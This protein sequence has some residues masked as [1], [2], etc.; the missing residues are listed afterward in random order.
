L[1]STTN[2]SLYGIGTNIAL[3][4]KTIPRRHNQFVRDNEMN[5]AANPKQ[6]REILHRIVKQYGLDVGDVDIIPTPVVREALRRFHL[7][8]LPSR[9]SLP[10]RA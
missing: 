6:A 7:G 9:L 3:F 2:C 1:V 4:E 10:P 8:L 5:V